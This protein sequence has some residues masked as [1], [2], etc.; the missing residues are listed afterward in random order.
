[1]QNA[2]RIRR[3]QYYS[4]TPMYVHFVQFAPFGTG[5]A[6]DPRELAARFE[7]SPGTYAAACA[8]RLMCYYILFF[9]FVFFPQE[10]GGGATRGQRAARRFAARDH[11]GR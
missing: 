3:Q 2:N 9:V 4:T 5:D 8:M 6:Q 7:I 10:R 1:M 11:G